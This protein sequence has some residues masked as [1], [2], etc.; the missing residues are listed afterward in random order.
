MRATKEITDWSVIAILWM[1]EAEFEGI[2]QKVAT[3]NGNLQK[4]VI[5]RW[6]DTGE[7]SWATLVEHL[8]DDLVN[9]KLLAQKI[10]KDHCKFIIVTVS[11]GNNE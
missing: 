10:A 5:K 9:K 6:F 3:Q 4:E 11:H 8:S 1:E 7:A 2:R